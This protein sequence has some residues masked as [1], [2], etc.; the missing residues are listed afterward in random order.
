MQTRV[1]QYKNLKEQLTELK[2]G[3]ESIVTLDEE[4]QGQGAVAIK[5]FYK[6]QIDVVDS[7]LR[8]I[9]RHVAFLSGIQGDTI[10]ANLSKTVFSSYIFR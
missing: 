9:N 3:F 6:V 10:E 1:G 2:K 5:G 8:L 4:L 7:W